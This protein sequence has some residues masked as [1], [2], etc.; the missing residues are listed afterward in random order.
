MSI[1]EIASEISG[2]E[3][4]PQESIIVSSESEGERIKSGFFYLSNFI[5]LFDR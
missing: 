4:S 3:I 1:Q 2:K 5:Y